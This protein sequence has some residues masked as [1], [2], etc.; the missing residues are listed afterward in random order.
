[1]GTIHS[2]ISLLLFGLLLKKVRNPL[3]KGADL[4]CLW[5]KLRSFVEI[6]IGIQKNGKS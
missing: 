4:R 2:Q 6:G 3:K 1:M 5:Y